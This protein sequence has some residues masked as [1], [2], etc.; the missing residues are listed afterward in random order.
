MHQCTSASSS[1]PVGAGL[2][3]CILRVKGSG[4]NGRAVPVSLFRNHEASSVL[5]AGMPSLYRVDQGL[6]LL[7]STGESWPGLPVLPWQGATPLH[8]W[9]SLSI[10]ACF[11]FP[12]PGC[13]PDKV[14]S[15]KNSLLFF[16]LTALVGVV[17]A[18]LWLNSF[19][20]LLPPD[21]LQTY[22]K[23]NWLLVKRVGLFI[24]RPHGV[25]VETESSGQE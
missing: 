9:S 13:A 16:I 3:L 2:C 15:S 12:V 18:F 1:P 8:H 21:N 20:C 7:G 6:A 23:G 25:I 24:L 11:A 5:F 10:L 14:G 19:V 17:L 4:R 22:S